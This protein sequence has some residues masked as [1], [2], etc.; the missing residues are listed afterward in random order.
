MA[1]P[2]KENGPLVGQLDAK[3]YGTGSSKEKELGWLQSLQ[4]RGEIRDGPRGMRR[5]RKAETH[6]PAWWKPRAKRTQC[7]YLT[8]SSLSV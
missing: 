5:I 3:A 4:G 2:G 8:V 7:V 1:Q 6:R